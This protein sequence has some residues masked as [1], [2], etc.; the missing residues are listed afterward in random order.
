M[1]AALLGWALLSLAT[2]VCSLAIERERGQG[3][4]YLSRRN[5]A[6]VD[7]QPVLP[8]PPV[9]HTPLSDKDDDYPTQVDPP[10]VLPP[11]GIPFDK[12]HPHFSTPPLVPPN[13]E[14]NVDDEDEQG[15][16]EDDP[17]VVLVRTYIDRIAAQ[18]P[19]VTIDFTGDEGPI[20]E[21]QVRQRHLL[22]LSSILT[23]SPV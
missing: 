4:A 15:M 2:T 21:E 7:H 6:G 13:Q 17:R 22:G 3:K 10:Y 12:P 11:V 16:D 1:K 14:D 9:D 23:W 8:C 19:N 5:N 18:T 20:Y